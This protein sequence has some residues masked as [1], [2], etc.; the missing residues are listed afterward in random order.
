MKAEI[1]Q[2]EL[3]AL[4]QADQATISRIER[5]KSINSK[6]LILL[7]KFVDQQL[8]AENDINDILETIRSSEELRALVIRVVDS[9][10]A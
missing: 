8:S 10:G 4:V 9:K 3:G 7:H 2:A 1:S 6:A 5:N